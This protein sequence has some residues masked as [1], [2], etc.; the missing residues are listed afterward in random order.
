MSKRTINFYAGPAGLPLEPLKKAQEELLDF[1]GT[2]MSVMEISHRSKE[3]DAVH[4]EAI[5]LTKELLGIPS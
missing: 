4:E 2:G 3:Y 1:A 5:A